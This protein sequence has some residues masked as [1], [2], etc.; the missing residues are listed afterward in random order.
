MASNIAATSTGR[1][2]RSALA[3]DQPYGWSQQG[4]TL[5]G[6]VEDVLGEEREDGLVPD[7]RV[8]RSQDP[9][10]LV[11]EVKELGLSAV[12]GQVPP[13]PQRL[14]HRHPVV[15]VAMDDEHRRADLFEVQ[16]RRVQLLHLRPGQRIAEP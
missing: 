1:L 9:V 4:R 5:P 13:Q 3:M 11:R 6:L 10:V 2:S 16:V 8:A 14:A 7:P 12:P 15:L